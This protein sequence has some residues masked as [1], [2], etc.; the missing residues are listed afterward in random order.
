MI[1]WMSVYRPLLKIGESDYN[2]EIK[3]SKKGRNVGNGDHLYLY[4]PKE[5]DSGGRDESI[6]LAHL[7]GVAYCS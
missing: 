1:I 6:V 3:V 2:W 4:I 5:M 7:V